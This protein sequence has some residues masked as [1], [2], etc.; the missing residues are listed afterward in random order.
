M[1]DEI[2]KQI[3]YLRNYGEA[4]QMQGSIPDEFFEAADTLKKLL[5]VY[6]A[7]K[8]EHFEIKGMLAIERHAIA[9][10]VSETNMRCLEGRVEAMDRALE[11]AQNN[12]TK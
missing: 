11:A 6:E 3:R 7:A 5:A 1:T 9:E 12:Q 8:A 2:R 10:L 4:V